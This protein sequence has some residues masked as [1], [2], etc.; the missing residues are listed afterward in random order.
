MSDRETACQLLT[1]AVG[2]HAQQAAEKGAQWIW[3]R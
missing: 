2:F 1:E 3:R